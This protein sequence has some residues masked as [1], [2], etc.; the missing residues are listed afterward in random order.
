MPFDHC[1]ANA[2]IKGATITEI[3]YIARKLGMKTLKESGIEKLKQ[4]ITSYKELQR[5]CISDFL[6]PVLL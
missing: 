1:L 6:T 4:G 5:F 2:I 3:E